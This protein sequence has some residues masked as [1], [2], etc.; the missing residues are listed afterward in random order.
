MRKTFKYR[1]YPTKSQITKLKNQ[2]EL[3]RWVYN[4]T[5]EMR[6]NAYETEHRSLSL[7]D[8][9]KFLKVWSSGEKPELKEVY[10]QV[11]QN[12]Q[13]RVDLAFKSFFKRVK[14]GMTPGYPRFRGSDRYDSF[15]F[16][17]TGFKIE[18]DGTKIYLS[19][20]GRV[21][22][23]LHRPVGGTIKTC[24]V[25]KTATDKWYISFS[26]EA[27]KPKPLHRTNKVVGIDVGLKTFVQISDGR[28]VKNP[29][30]FKE[31]QTKLTRAQRK[32]SRAK[33]DTKK[34]SKQRKI[35]AKVHEKIKNKRT[36][37]CHK[38]A[39]SLVKDYDLIA[40]EDL[41]IKK[42][43]EQKKFS[44]SIADASWGQLLEILTYK[45]EEA[46]KIV[47]AV[48]PK[49]TTQ[50]CSKCMAIVPKTLKDRVHTCPHCGLSIDRDLNASINIL[51]LGLESV[52]R[53]SQRLTAVALEK[54]LGSPR[55]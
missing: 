41:S 30:F 39:R 16:K 43:L 17:Q 26:C 47:T 8:T 40:F 29:R 42:M 36:D 51:R 31:S 18:E 52:E 54:A 46:G 28:S 37:F 35:V 33:K 14:A 19:K 5:L 27:E 12:V 7:Y 2:L 15:T 53:P 13:L 49:N 25:Q 55:L 50:Q 3:S 34:R 11:L 32:L 22:I 4:K 48:N 20:T 44:K 6:K 21:P 23:I 24:T 1:I 9:N 45:A 38:T 10:S